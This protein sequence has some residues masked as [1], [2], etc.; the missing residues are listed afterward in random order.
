M[1]RASPGLGRPR[2]PSPESLSLPVLLLAAADA[3]VLESKGAKAD[4]IQQ[5]LGVDDDG[6]FQQ[7]LDAIEIEGA[8]LWPAGTDDQRVRTFRRGVSGI[9]VTNSSVEPCS[10]FGNGNGIVGAHVRTFRDECFG[11]AY[12]RG[13][14]HGICV[15]LIGKSP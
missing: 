12:R 10:S 6:L 9:T 4:G 8:K 7:G 14:G 2:R 11:Q 15:Q 3:D 5:V 1:R 13:S